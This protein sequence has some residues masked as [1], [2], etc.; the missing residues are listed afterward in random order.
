MFET[1]NTRFTEMV[2]T[3]TGTGKT[4][5]S[6]ATRIEFTQAGLK[7][8]VETPLFGIGIANS[9][10]I[11]QQVIIGFDTYLH[12]NYV[13]LLACVGIIGTALFYSAVFTSLLSVLKKGKTNSAKAVLVAILI[14]VWLII[15]VGYV[16]YAEKTT[17]IYTVL[18][19]LY[20]LPVN[21]ESH[22]SLHGRGLYD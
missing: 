18:M 3:F 17:Y 19:G 21:Y 11:T 20:A 5:V 13:E 22:H 9:G 12:N 15:Q 2:N 7:Q 10:L 6:T 1:L 14:I 4:S 8:F 16:S